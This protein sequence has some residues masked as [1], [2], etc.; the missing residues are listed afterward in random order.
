MGAGMRPFRLG[1]HP[2][3]DYKLVIDYFTSRGDY[4]ERAFDRFFNAAEPKR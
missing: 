1:P 2:S 4:E 3:L